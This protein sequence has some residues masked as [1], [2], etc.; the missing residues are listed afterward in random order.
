MGAPR[1]RLRAVGLGGR[2][3]QRRTGRVGVVVVG[4]ARARYHAGVR[5]RVGFCLGT[6]AD[7]AACPARGKRVGRGDDGDY[8]SAHL[9]VRRGGVGAADRLPYA[10]D[11]ERAGS[12]EQRRH[13]DGHHDAAPPRRG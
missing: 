11:R 8:G 9:G 13:G 1:R 5:H 2:S 12:P 6:Q 7:G 3:E 10:R 4:G